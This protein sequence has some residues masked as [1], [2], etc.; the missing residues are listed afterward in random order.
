MELNTTLMLNT[1]SAI[2]FENLKQYPVS[3][4][5]ADLEEFIFAII[6]QESDF[7]KITNT[8]YSLQ[9]VT[10]LAYWLELDHMHNHAY[11]Q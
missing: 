1:A 9:C 10:V 4:R 2:S 6:Q 5:Q 8:Q 3:S 11:K 7:T